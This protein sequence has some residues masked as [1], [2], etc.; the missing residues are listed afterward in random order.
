MNLKEAYILGKSS[1]IDGANTI[2]CN[3]KIFA[4]NEL[5]EAW[6]KGRK[7]AKKK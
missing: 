5:K 1:V 7:E 2:N 6:E 3:F 4:T